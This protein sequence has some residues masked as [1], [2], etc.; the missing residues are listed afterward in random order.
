MNWL[1][2]A[3]LAM[4]VAMLL[5]AGLF[6]VLFLATGEVVPRQRAAMFGRWAVL[7]LLTYSNLVIFGRVFDA[8]RDILR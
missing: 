1:F 5:A 2:W 7:V 8:L 6:G 4:M 3:A